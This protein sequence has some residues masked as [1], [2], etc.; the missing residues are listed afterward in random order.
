[1]VT[2]LQQSGFEAQA[3]YDGPTGLA[4]ARAFRPHVILL[5]IGLPGMDGYQVAEAIRRASGFEK[6]RVIVVSGYGEEQ[7]RRRSQEAGCTLHL[8]K[9]V[10]IE[11]LLNLL[12]QPDPDPEDDSSQEPR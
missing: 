8:V 4:T 11:S 2:L 3:A 12:N 10:D 9:P 6:L 1:M 7:A 5:D